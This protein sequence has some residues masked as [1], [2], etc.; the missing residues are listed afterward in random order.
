MRAAIPPER[1][2]VFDVADGWEPLCP[3]LVKKSL[4]KLPSR[5]RTRTKTS[6][7]WSGAKCTGPAALWRPLSAAAPDVGRER[8]GTH[9]RSGRACGLLFR[10]R[11]GG[12]SMSTKSDADE[13]KAAVAAYHAALSSLD[14]ENPDA[15]GARGQRNHSRTGIRGNHRGLECGQ[16]GPRPLLRRFFRAESSPSCRP[17]CPG[18]GRC[19]LLDRHHDRRRKNEGGRIVVAAGLR[20]AGVG[21]ARRA[22]G[23]SSA[24][25]RF[26]FRTDRR[27]Q[28][29]ALG[30]CAGEVIHSQRSGR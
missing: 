5:T 22:P 21:E 2:L 10:W 7:N 27:P 15:V 1:L 16:E 20:Y 4:P 14:P 28:S 12:R 18:L 3:F 6:G 23:W 24:T 8:S 26:Q 11:S 17:S 19:R 9:R 29:S 30:G 13:V 25:L